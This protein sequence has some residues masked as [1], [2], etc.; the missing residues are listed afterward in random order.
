[1]VAKH[2][3]WNEKQHGVFMLAAADMSFYFDKVHNRQCTSRHFMPEV[4]PKLEKQD[5]KVCPNT[6]IDAQIST[7]SENSTTNSLISSV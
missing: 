1:M 2:K 3:I 5:I 6:I 7:F 4:N